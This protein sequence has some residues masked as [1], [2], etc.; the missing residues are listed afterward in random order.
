MDPILLRFLERMLVVLIGGM[1]IYLGYRLF[2]KLPNERNSEGKVELPGD[3]SIYLSRV[4]PGVFFALFGC[5]VVGLSLQNAI[6]WRTS[7]ADAG[8]PKVASAA[9]AVRSSEFI[10]IGGADADRGRD[11]TP[12]RARVSRNIRTLERAIDGIAEGLEPQARNDLTQA[13]DEA[14]R[15]LILSVWDADWGNAQQFATWA[16]R[17]GIGEPPDGAAEP[18]RLYRGGK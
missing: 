4:G 17:G 10:G 1:A 9:S 13:F 7:A 11:R 8:N 5:A 14:K 18:A 2:I 16:L 6:E 3:V 12:E 15:A